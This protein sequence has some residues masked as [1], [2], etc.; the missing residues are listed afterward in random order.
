MGLGS[1]ANMKGKTIIFT[2]WPATQYLVEVLFR[3]LGLEIFVLRSE[4]GDDDRASI[5]ARFD[6]PDDIYQHLL[7]S[8]RSSTFSLNLQ[9]VYHRP[10]IMEFP[11]NINT[12]LYIIEPYSGKMWYDGKYGTTTSSDCGY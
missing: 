12:V 6:N 7:L 5:L 2:T 3:N 8:S 9:K 11:D 10:V 1:N 4:I